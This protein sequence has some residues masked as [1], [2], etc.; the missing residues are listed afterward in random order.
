MK[1]KKQIR[2]RNKSNKFRKMKGA[3]GNFSMPMT[4]GINTNLSSGDRIIRQAA[5]EEQR[6][7]TKTQNTDKLRTV[8]AVLQHQQGFPE[9][10]KLAFAAK[11]MIDKESLERMEAEY[12]KSEEY[13]NKVKTKS[14]NLWSRIM[15]QDELKKIFI[16]FMDRYNDKRPEDSKLLNTHP[17]QHKHLYYT[18][19]KHRVDYENEFNE[20]YEEVVTIDIGKK[21]RERGYEIFPQQ[22]FDGIENEI[23]FYESILEAI[24]YEKAKEESY[25]LWNGMNQSELDE[26]FRDFMNIYNDKRPEDSKLRDIYNK[27]KHFN[28]YSTFTKRGVV[29]ENEFNELYKNVVKFD[30]QFQETS[31]TSDPPLTFGMSE[32]QIYTQQFFYGIENEIL[33]Y[34]SILEAIKKYNNRNE[35]PGKLQ[36]IERGGKRKTKKRKTK[37]R[38]SRRRKSRIYVYKNKS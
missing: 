4:N 15:D 34:E 16:I 32:N 11:G 6:K 19:T 26:I 28:I 31:K 38:K 30:I 20:L 27:Q 17:E 13:L 12:L 1:S 18:F 33:F 14:Y 7:Q 25:K 36:G 22:F 21:K 23:L 35:Q 8:S 2:R 10:A 5:L 24:K 37:K 9:F 29:S 3:G